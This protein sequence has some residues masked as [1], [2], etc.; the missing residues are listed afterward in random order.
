MNFRKWQVQDNT[1][2]LIL[3]M[4]L[5]AYATSCIPQRQTIQHTAYLFRIMVGFWGTE[6]VVVQIEALMPRKPHCNL[7]SSSLSVLLV[8]YII[9]SIYTDGLKHTLIFQV[10]T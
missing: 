5:V 8:P 7:F 9:T 1:D 6:N 10:M 2:V 4:F 3:R